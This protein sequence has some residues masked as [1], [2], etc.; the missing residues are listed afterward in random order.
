MTP[1]H[2]NARDVPRHGVHL[3][4]GQHEPHRLL[5]VHRHLRCLVPGPNL[6]GRGC[7]RLSVARGRAVS[8][9]ISGALALQLLASHQLL[10]VHSPLFRAPQARP[11]LPTVGR[12]G[13]QAAKDAV[14]KA[15]PWMMRLGGTEGSRHTDMVG[16]GSGT[17][18][19]VRGHAS[20]TT[21]TVPPTRP[22][23]GRL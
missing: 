9:T 10:Q 19:H 6:K 16:R 15:S 5:V 20:L 11:A 14:L 17:A 21:E 23:H 22:R 13:R 4:L 2:T 3:Q 18:P 12:C 1:S 7:Q 8:I